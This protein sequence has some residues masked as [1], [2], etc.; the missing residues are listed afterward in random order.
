M[1]RLK[2]NKRLVPLYLKSNLLW[3]SALTRK[4][5]S[6]MLCKASLRVLLKIR[7]WQTRMRL[8]IRYNSN[9]KPGWIRFPLTTPTMTFRRSSTAT[10]VSWPLS[11]FSRFTISEC[12]TSRCSSKCI[13][14]SRTLVQYRCW[15]SSSF[16]SRTA[17]GP[18][19]SQTFRFWL[20]EL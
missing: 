9:R 8:A 16:T 17:E 3:V 2:T 20:L 10:R 18:M 6:K 1:L 19:G 14:N 5:Q 11:S 13:Q 15:G 12:T 4:R 7:L